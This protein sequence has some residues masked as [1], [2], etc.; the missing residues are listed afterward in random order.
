MD[1]DTEMHY[2]KYFFTVDSVI[3][4]LPFLIIYLLQGLNRLGN[5]NIHGRVKIADRWEEDR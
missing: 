2:T 4:I 1:E 3:W 5:E